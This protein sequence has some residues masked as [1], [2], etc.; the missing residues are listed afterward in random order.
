MASFAQILWVCWTT[1]LNFNVYLIKRLAKYIDHDKTNRYLFLTNIVLDLKPLHRLPRTIN[2]SENDFFLLKF[3][4]LLIQLIMICLSSNGV[5]TEI[6]CILLNQ[7]KL[8]IITW[9]FHVNNTFHLISVQKKY[10]AWLL[11]L[12]FIIRIIWEPSCCHNTRSAR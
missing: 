7:C 5:R 12:P 10:I 1:N 4:V 8:C 3:P 11:W 2:L 6:H 9:M